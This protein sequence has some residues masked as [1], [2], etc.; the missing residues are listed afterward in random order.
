MGIRET[1]AVMK[2]WI[3]IASLV[4]LAKLASSQGRW[5]V[6]EQCKGKQDGSDCAYLCLAMNCGPPYTKCYKQKCINAGWPV[7]EQ[8]KGKRDGSDCNFLCKA[9][10]CGP[11]YTKCYKQK[12]ITVG[13]PPKAFCDGKPDGTPC[14]QKCGDK[15]CR[16]EYNRCK[17][18]ICQEA[19][20]LTKC[21][22]K[23][24]GTR[25]T[26]SYSKLCDTE[27]CKAMCY[28]DRCWR[29][30]YPKN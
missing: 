30:A 1:Q 21:L 8:Y 3:S 26:I 12:C 18:G 7:N 25:C 9:M 23:S 20:N 11:P 4:V 6:N 16:S 13:W 29:L 17:K 10:N 19:R 2:A 27:R 28:E 22:G 14:N 24:N 5:D 15:K